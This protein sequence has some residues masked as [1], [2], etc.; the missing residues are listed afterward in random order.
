M[1]KGQLVASG[2]GAQIAQLAKGKVYLLEQS[3]EQNLH[4]SFFVKDR[5]EENGRAVIRVLSAQEQPG[6][7]QPPTVEDGFLCALKKI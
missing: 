5:T 4:G 2:T 3:M 7:L 6:T 1:D